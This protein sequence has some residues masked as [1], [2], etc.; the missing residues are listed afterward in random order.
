MVIWLA[1]QG[2]AVTIDGRE[3]APAAFRE[4]S[5]ID[6][7]TGQ[8]IPFAERVTSG[9]GVGVP[10]TLRTWQRA[11][12]RFGTLPLAELLRP[13]IRAAED[14]FEVDQ[15]FHDQTAANADR[16]QAIVPTRELFL[17]GGSP[18]PVGST[19]RNPDLARTYRLAARTGGRAFYQG[20][21]AQAIIDTVQHPPVAPDATIRCGPA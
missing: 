11:A 17:P 2:R 15:T 3:T 12:G 20:R 5:F 10:G 21:I 6:P 8:P 4:D 1:R 13:A 16:F 19:F 18:P 14:G 9:L 7:A